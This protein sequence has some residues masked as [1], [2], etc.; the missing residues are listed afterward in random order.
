MILDRINFIINM[1]FVFLV[2]TL[3]YFLYNWL[4]TKT[5]IGWQGVAYFAFIML[6]SAM[7]YN[8]LKNYFKLKEKNNINVVHFW[9]VYLLN[10][11]VYVILG[12]FYLMPPKIGSFLFVF[13]IL[14]LFLDNRLVIIILPQL[15]QAIADKKKKIEEL[16][17]KVKQAEKENNL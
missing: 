9:S 8:K 5:G 3:L 14:W 12:L 1:L 2:T 4:G 17:K 16:N 11:V 13:I 7:M 6:S 10:F 15:K